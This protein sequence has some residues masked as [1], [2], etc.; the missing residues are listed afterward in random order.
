VSDDRETTTTV[1][2]GYLAGRTRH[3][4]VVGFPEELVGMGWPGPP[5]PL[6]PR[7]L[8]AS[9]R[10]PVHLYADH[11]TAWRIDGEPNGK[12]EAWHIID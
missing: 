11:E 4:L 9:H 1:I 2:H 5:F 3:D 12:T 8:D 10:V 6:L 7:Y